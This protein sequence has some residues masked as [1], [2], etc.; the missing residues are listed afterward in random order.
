MSFTTFQEI[1]KARRAAEL[2]RTGIKV[3]V[4]DGVSY[5]FP[6]GHLMPIASTI[7]LKAETIAAWLA[8]LNMIRKERCT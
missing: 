5:L 4:R 8:A 2:S 6:D 7:D 3:I 1:G